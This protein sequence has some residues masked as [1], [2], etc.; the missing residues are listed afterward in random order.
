M[1]KIVGIRPLTIE[2]T[3][4]EG[5]G[6]LIPGE[7]VSIQLENVPFYKVAEVEPGKFV[8]LPEG[9]SFGSA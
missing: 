9:T 4:M 6:E 5:P 1:R 2:M 7:I 3:A 8:L